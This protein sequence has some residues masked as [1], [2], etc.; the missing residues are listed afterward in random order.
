MLKLL[1]AVWIIRKLAKLVSKPVSLREQWLPP[2]R[3]VLFLT[4]PVGAQASSV[5][6]G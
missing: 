1:L 4:T 5:Y 6:E 3:K 2:L